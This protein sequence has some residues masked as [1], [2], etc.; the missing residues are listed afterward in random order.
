MR[1]ILP[2]FL[3][4]AAA[5]A[6]NSL[7]HRLD[8]LESQMRELRVETVY[9][10]FGANA[11]SAYP[12]LTSWGLYFE[13]EAL[14]WKFF[15]GG[16]D[17]T[18]V[19][20]PNISSTTLVD[21]LEYLDFDWR[22]AYRFTLGYQLDSPDLDLWASFTRFTTD[23]DTSVK[24]PLG[25]NSRIFPNQNVSENID[26]MK[27]SQSCDFA[28]NVLDINLGRNYFLRKT[29]SMH[30]FIGIRGAKID[31]RTKTIWEGSIISDYAYKSSNEFW[32][33]GIL[34][35]TEA[36]W[37]FDTNWSLFG[38]LLGSLLYGWYDV[39]TTIQQIYPSA[40]NDLKLDSDLRRVV[41]NM[42]TDVGVTWE[43]VPCQRRVRVAVTLAYEF[44]YWWAYNQTLHTKGGSLQYAWDRLA[45]DFGMQGVRFNVGLDF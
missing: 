45:E 11:A 32:G 1:R 21:R 10:N 25:V 23:Q 40:V 2:Y 42:T 27:A 3:L 20:Q 29:F 24:Q 44:Q 34:G 22:F 6:A 41:P 33:L 16:T 35:G 36:R 38:S 5:C 13:G 43:Y 39:D 4:S 28:Y 37:H 8:V 12:Y 7:D 31:E 18:Y 9:G 26:Y 14:C 17:Y 15:L 19:N 30:P